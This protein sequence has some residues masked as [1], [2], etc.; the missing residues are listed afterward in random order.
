M[1]KGDHITLTVHVKTDTPC[2][3]SIFEFESNA[4]GHSEVSSINIPVSNEFSEFQVSKILIYDNV[5]YIAA[6]FVLTNNVGTAYVDNI[7]ISKR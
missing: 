6:R 4:S 7:K 3:F 1:S 2:I 5:Q